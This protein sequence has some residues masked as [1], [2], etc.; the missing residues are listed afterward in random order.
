MFLDADLREIYRSPGDLESLPCNL[1]LKVSFVRI[2][3]RAAARTGRETTPAG[4]GRF[5]SLWGLQGAAQHRSLD[6]R[7]I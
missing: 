3:L 2:R 1:H 6:L 4:V 5:N 7:E